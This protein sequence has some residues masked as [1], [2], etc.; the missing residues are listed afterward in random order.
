MSSKYPVQYRIKLPVIEVPA[1]THEYPDKKATRHVGAEVVEVI[2]TVPGR[3]KKTFN[4]KDQYKHGAILDRLDADKTELIVNEDER[5]L[6][7]DRFEDF[8]YGRVDRNVA[9]TCRAVQD[10]ESFTLAPVAA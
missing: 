4:L 7:L 2:L 10:A 8:D 5:K 1:P 6:I 9:K 3:E